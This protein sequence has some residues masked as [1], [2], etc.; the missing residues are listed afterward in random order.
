MDFDRPDTDAMMAAFMSSDFSRDEKTWNEEVDKARAVD[1]SYVPEPDADGNYTTPV[2]ERLRDSW[3][4]YR[5][6][7]LDDEQMQALLDRCLDNLD[8]MLLVMKQCV[9]EGLDDPSNPI[10][11]SIKTGFYEHREAVQLMKQ[12]FDANNRK[13]IEDGLRAA[14]VATNRLMDAFAFFQRLRAAVA[15]VHCPHCE[16]ENH[17]SSTKCVECGQPLPGLP[18]QPEPRLLAVAADGVSSDEN[19]AVTTPNFQRITEALARWGVHEMEDDELLAEIEDI[20]ASM[21][22]HKDANDSERR[23]MEGVT[24]EELKVMQTLLDGTDKALKANLEALDKMKLYWQDLDPEHI[25]IGF[26]MLG[27]ATAQMLEAYQLSQAVVNKVEA[28]ARS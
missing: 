11:V 23:D 20:E 8:N 2:L 17:K 12:F 16:V 10:T 3:Q 5:D 26:D 27:K 28:A 14:Q 7:K 25:R 1:D 9:Q 19:A 6:G 4:D 15:H 24:G 18:D 13:A 21:R 22:A